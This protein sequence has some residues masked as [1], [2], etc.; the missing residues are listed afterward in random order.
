MRVSPQGVAF[1]AAHEGIVPAPYFDSV[2][3]LTWGVGHTSAAG[4]PEPASMPMDMPANLDAAV[5]EALRVFARDLERYAAEVEQ[6]VNVPM[7][8][9][10]FDA[11]VSFHYNTG[12][13]GRATWVDQWNAGKKAAAG[14]SIMNWSKPP[15]IIPRRKAE[16]TLW[17]TGDYGKTTAA[18]WGTDGNGRVIW[19]PLRTLT[20]ADLAAPITSPRP[21]E[22]QPTPVSDTPSAPVKG[23]A[24]TAAAV[25]L[26]VAFLAFF[27][28]S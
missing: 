10:E 2:G 4:P 17:R 21:P 23:Y 14:G 8:Q 22:P 20:Q 25:V 6:T 26:I 18:V 13:I 19:K 24:V 1:I 12:A 5:T 3:V 9:H 28:F 11:A 16:Q 7:A 27:G 15:E